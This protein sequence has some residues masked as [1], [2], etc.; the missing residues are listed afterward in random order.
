MN[1]G[2]HNLVYAMT[3]Y[4]GSRFR[5]A[6]GYGL[7]SR[8]RSKATIKATVYNHARTPRDETALVLVSRASQPLCAV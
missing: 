3:R 6:Q 1:L 2:E 8:T 5:V 4:R 7:I